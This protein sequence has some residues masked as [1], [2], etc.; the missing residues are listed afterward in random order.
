MPG[1]SGLRPLC[2]LSCASIWLCPGYPPTVLQ[3][4]VFMDMKDAVSMQIS[5][6]LK[7]QGVLCQLLHLRCNLAGVQVSVV[8]A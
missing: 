1:A 6:W 4:I 5:C 7:L 3:A 8:Q 2:N